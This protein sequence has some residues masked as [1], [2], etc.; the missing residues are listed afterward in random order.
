MKIPRIIVLLLL[1]A[2]LPALA[3]KPRRIVSMGLCTDQLLLMLAD[4]EHDVRHLLIDQGPGPEGLPGVL[5]VDSLRA[6]A[7]PST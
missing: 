5:F 1:L 4:P 7:P 2:S 3:E 6:A